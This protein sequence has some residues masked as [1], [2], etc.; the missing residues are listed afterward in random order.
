MPLRVQPTLGA[1]FHRRTHGLQLAPEPAS[2]LVGPR[3]ADAVIPDVLEDSGQWSAAPEVPRK[4]PGSGIVSS[5]GWRSWMRRAG[6]EAGWARVASRSRGGR[7]TTAS[8]GALASMHSHR[9]KTRRHD[10][11]AP[12]VHR[13]QAITRRVQGRRGFPSAWTEPPFAARRRTRRGPPRGRPSLL[14][15]RHGLR[16]HARAPETSR[17]FEWWRDR[18]SARRTATRSPSARGPVAAVPRGRC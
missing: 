10:Q 8:Q 4:P 9:G 6:W 7:R 2:D 3:G 13:G 17:P 16:A 15:G 14:R 12:E 11:L 5:R 1:Y 18:A